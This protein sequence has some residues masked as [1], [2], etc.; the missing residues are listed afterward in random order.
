MLY[1]LTAALALATA[2]TAPASAVVVDY[3]TNG[4][5]ETGPAITANGG[6]WQIF[7]GSY[8]GWTGTAGGIEVQTTGTLPGV[9]AN[10]G[11]RYVE[12]D[13]TGNYTLSQLITGLSA[14]EYTLSFAYRPRTSDA[15]TNGISY[16]FGSL[17]TSVTANAAY[18]TG[19][20]TI[21]QHVVQIATAGNY[22][23]SFTGV[24]GSNGTGGLLDSVSLTR[25]VAPVPVPAAGLLL[26]GG[27]GG[28]AALR[29]RKRA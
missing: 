20:W 26:L 4:S 8:S 3:V 2:M 19:A 13:G 21:V 24:G 12:M 28:L 25:D 5:F 18:T 6:K 11:S 22:A 27:I 15:D 17:T 1:K 9:S 14:G 7:P 16:T 23:L 10:H 29:R